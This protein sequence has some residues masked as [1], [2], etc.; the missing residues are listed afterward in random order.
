MN[1]TVISLPYNRS[2]HNNPILRRPYPLRT[3]PTTDYL[4]VIC[5]L[6]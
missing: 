6:V 4:V 2:F 3:L 1:V 5:D